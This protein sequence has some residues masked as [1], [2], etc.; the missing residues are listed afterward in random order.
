MESRGLLPKPHDSCSC[1]PSQRRHLSMSGILVA[2]CLA[3]GP[4]HSPQETYFTTHALDANPAVLPEM[5]GYPHIHCSVHPPLC[6]PACQGP[7]QA[8]HHP[9]LNAEAPQ[10]PVLPVVREA[11]LL[12]LHFSSCSGFYFPAWGPGFR[13]GHKTSGG[14]G[15]PS[16]GHQSGPGCLDSSAY[17]VSSEKMLETFLS[18]ALDNPIPLYCSPAWTRMREEALPETVRAGLHLIWEHTSLGY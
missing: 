7:P 5:L 12:W 9:G 17:H 14:E 16:D 15:L 18:R 8:L 11:P 1:S 10:P 13:F 4:S 6:H 3:Q 2:Q